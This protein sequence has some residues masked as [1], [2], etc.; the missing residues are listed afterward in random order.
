VSATFR[1]TRTKNGQNN[2]EIEFNTGI[3]FTRF[4]QKY[5]PEEGKQR[6]EE[7]RQNLQKRLQVFMELIDGGSFKGISMSYEYAEQLIRLMDTGLLLC[8]S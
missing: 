3:F 1:H 7:Q 8:L 6:R 4:R 5:H 2:N